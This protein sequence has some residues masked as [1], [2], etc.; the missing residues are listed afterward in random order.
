MLRTGRDFSP[1][2]WPPRAAPQLLVTAKMRVAC[3]HFRAHRSHRCLRTA[4]CLPPLAAQAHT[5]PPTTVKG[6]SQG[7]GFW[8]KS[9]LIPESAV[10]EVQS[11]FSNR[12][13]PSPF[14]RQPR[15]TAIVC[16]ILGVS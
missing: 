14:R 8:I 4:D 2:E 5:A 16:I 12:D 6:S 9:S 15:A 1:V 13:V 10:S 7:G 3:L 11:V